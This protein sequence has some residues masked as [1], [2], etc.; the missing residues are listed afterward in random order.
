MG[1]G[2]RAAPVVEEAAGA[3]R[4]GAAEEDFRMLGVLL[5][6]LV[7]LWISLGK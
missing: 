5:K 2:I 4:Q 7:L 1:R 6:A 3:H